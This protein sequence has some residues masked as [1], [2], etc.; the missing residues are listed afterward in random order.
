MGGPFELTGNTLAGTNTLMFPGA[1]VDAEGRMIW[2]RRGQEVKNT[3]ASSRL[4][5]SLDSLDTMASPAL[6][7][8]ALIL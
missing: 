8:A 1:A 2:Q 6:L 7:F 5:L 3:F 4:M